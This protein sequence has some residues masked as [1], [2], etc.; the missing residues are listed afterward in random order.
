MPN[1]TSNRVDIEGEEA[2]I[3]AFLDAVKWEDELCLPR[4]H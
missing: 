2:D 1:W 3:R 4:G